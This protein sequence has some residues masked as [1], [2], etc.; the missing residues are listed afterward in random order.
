MKNTLQINNIT[1]KSN[2]FMSQ[3]QCTLIYVA[4]ANGKELKPVMVNTLKI[5]KHPLI[6][7]QTHTYI[8]HTHTHTQAY[9]YLQL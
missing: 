1:N 3:L 2:G 7:I 8:T 6:H 9:I 4:L 5:M